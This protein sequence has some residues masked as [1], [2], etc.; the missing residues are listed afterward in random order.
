MFAYN[1]SIDINNVNAIA[2][3]ITI[4]LLTNFDVLST[5]AKIM[6]NKYVWDVVDNNFVMNI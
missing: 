2:K 3:H 6:G 5:N 1:H 4:T